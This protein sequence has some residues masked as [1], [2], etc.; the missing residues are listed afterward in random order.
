MHE[1]FSPTFDVDVSS[2]HEPT[3]DKSLSRPI[4]KASKFVHSD[5]ADQL[6]IIQHLL[7]KRHFDRQ[8]E[9]LFYWHADFKQR[10]REINCTEPHFHVL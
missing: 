5:S 2:K 7:K 9:R 3:P 8:P 10:Q 6:Q 4:P 1:E